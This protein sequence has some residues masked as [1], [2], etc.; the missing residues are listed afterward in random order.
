M[1]PERKWSIERLLASEQANCGKNVTCL[2]ARSFIYRR[3]L[4]AFCADTL[5]VVYFGWQSTVA[6]EQSTTSD[7]V[8]S[9]AGF[10]FGPALFISLWLVGHVHSLAA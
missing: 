9:F 10:A 2:R 1:R 6:L 3:V 7:A 8:V 5:V 4:S